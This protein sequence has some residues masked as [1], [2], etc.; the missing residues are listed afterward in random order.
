[1]TEQNDDNTHIHIVL[2]K[3]T[4]VQHYRIIKKIGAGGMGEVYLAEDTKLKRQVA[5]KF[6]PHHY[7]PNDDIKLRFQREA[8]AV[9]KLNH[10][11]IVT[12]HEVSEFNGR[13]FFV[14]E[15]IDGNS[16]HHFIKEE[17]LPIDSI[18]EYAIQTCQGLGEAHRNGIIHRDIKPA[19]I[20]VDNTNRIKLLDFGLA[21][22]EGDDKLTKTGSTL[23]TVAYMSP[24]QVSGREI[25]H[26]SDLFSLG[27]VLY[28]LLCGRTPFKKD[29][30]GATLKAIIE[31]DPEPLSRYK[32]E[33]PDKLQEIISQ[34]IEKDKELRYQSAEGVIADLKRLMYDS[35]QSSFRPEQSKK[36]NIFLLPISI[37]VVAI[38]LITVWTLLFNNKEDTK[39]IKIPVLV[40]L[41]F[42]NLGSDKDEYFADGIREE[43]GSRLSSIK[44]LSVISQ[45]SADNYKKTDKSIEQIGTETGADYV[46]E[47]TIRWDKSG[48]IDRIRITP[49]LTKTSDNYLMW[50]EN[51]EEQLVQIF[52]VQ[53]KIAEQIVN[54]L[55]LTLV[56]TDKAAPDYAPTTNMEAYN[57]YLRGLEISSHTFRMSEFQ[58]SVSMFD[59][60]IALDS[61]FALAWAHKSINHSTFNFFFTT[62]D[63]NYH[64]EEA[65][66]AAEKSLA[67]AYNL[68]SAK[69]AMGTYYNYI[70]RDYDKALE[71]F[72]SAK[73]ETIS[74]AELSQAIGVVKMRQGEWNEALSHFEEAIQI[75]PLN[76]IRYYYIANCL[77]MTRDYE[78]GEKYINRALVLD[79]TNVD[80]AYMK[81]FVNQLRYGTIEHEENSFSKLTDKAGLAEISTYEL[82]SATALG[83]WRFII[84]RIDYK[85]EIKNIRRLG[86]IRGSINERQ[87]HMLHL[88]IA[89]IYDLIGHNDSALVHYD[90]SRIILENVIEQGVYEFH[91]F[92]ELGVS[93]AFLG[94]KDEA[95]EAGITAKE[96][97]AV[98][99]CHW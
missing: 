41:P 82:V 9:A 97:M 87:Q 84:D 21:T 89:Q 65:L 78:A 25:D 75:D 56:D 80:A 59:S 7:L 38:V 69:I 46:L 60:A 64:N 3:D 31:K 24:E 19:N 2:A 48:N 70:E 73:S 10:P 32:S 28:E 18:I 91:A 27:V 5:L 98:S 79:P 68:P 94:M 35:Q 36:K 71:Y 22:S 14:M 92:A 53:S 26:R 30:E 62:V 86:N 90:S 67:L 96:L 20:A 61:S 81:I 15:N 99:D 49:R 29:N 42:E 23:G 77:S 34:L 55:G 85:L 39:E 95:I 16:L 40:V 74:N 12:I 6:L 50:A 37:S 8:Q 76:D 13:P 88:S 1:M 66:R 57:Y 63:F 51:Y 47:A 44:G 58:E 83:L 43:I 52:V 72:A 17:A 45:R 54:A 4:M 11:N 33:V 93:Y